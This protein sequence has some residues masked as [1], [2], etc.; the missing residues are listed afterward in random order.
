[1]SHHPHSALQ[2]YQFLY[3]LHQNTPS[4]EIFDSILL[5]LKTPRFEPVS[6]LA[7]RWRPIFQTEMPSLLDQFE[8][9]LA[10]AAQSPAYDSLLMSVSDHYP[11]VYRV[12]CFLENDLQLELFVRCLCLDLST[13]V[14]HEEIKETIIQFLTELPSDIREYVEEIL[15]EDDH[16]YL[17]RNDTVT[18]MMN[19]RKTADASS[20]DGFLD[21]DKVYE[22][23]DDEYTFDMFMAILQSNMSDGAPW[24]QTCQE[25]YQLVAEKGIWER[26]APLLQQ[27]YIKSDT[28]DYASYED[29]VQQNFLDDGGQ[30]YLDDE[31]KRAQVEHMMSKLTM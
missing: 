3:T 30:Q 28:Q 19:R 17:S 2:I 6:V 5:D 7:D 23:I 27:V 24:S 11:L 15:I 18:M 12:S 16:H 31:I 10:S 1:M 21:M 14:H 25:I 20:F 8:Q 13:P 4:K 26:L 22:V 29:Y 9:L